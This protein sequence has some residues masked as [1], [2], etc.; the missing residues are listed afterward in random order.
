M[1]IFQT[2]WTA[3]T[4]ENELLSRIVFIPITFLENLLSMLIFTT[5]LNITTT[6]KRKIKYVLLVSI[7]GTTFNILI[8]NPYR[9]FINLALMIICIKVFFKTKVIK[10]ILAVIIPVLV[11]V[12]CESIIAKIS[13]MILHIDVSSLSIIPIY[14]LI[15]ALIVQLFVFIVYLLIKYSKVQISLLESMSKKSKAMLLL[16]LIFAILAFS[17]QFLITGFY[18][19][20]LPIYIVIFSN[21]SLIAYFL[22]SIYSLTK[23]TQLEI[24]SLSLE[25]EKE[26]NRILKASQDEL[27]GFR[28]D[29]SNIMCTIG[30]YVLVSDMDG[31]KKYYSQIQK[32]ITKINN[33]SALNPDRINNPA[34]FVLISSKYSKALEL[35][36]EMNINVFLNLNTLNMKIYEFTRTLGIL[37]DNAIEAAKECDVKTINLEIRKDSARNRQ[38]LLIENTYKNKDIDT[39]KIYD[40]NFSTK[41]GNSGLGLWEV[42]KILKRNTNLN[43]Y[44]TKN[45]EFFRQQLEMYNI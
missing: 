1:E 45:Q 3:L 36:I 21:I 9:S 11:T 17:F 28:H 5:L 13:F 33:L 15:I 27:H 18:L 32:D 29:F 44:T 12:L 40:K 25:Q 31:L 39:E 41:K 23:T 37:L 10:T 30:G 20:K 42:R 7:L 35:G 14:R 4:N 19:N 26:A 43:L 6:R 2:I 16:N 8:P 34:V 24:T 38:I 22:L